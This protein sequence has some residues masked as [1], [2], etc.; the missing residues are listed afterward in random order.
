[1]SR[2][3][4]LADSADKDIAG[5][6]TLDGL[7]VSGDVAVDTDTLF[8]D[9]SAD[10]VGIGTSSPDRTLTVNSGGTN[11]VATFESTDS[12]AV[13][14]VAD[15]NSANT[16]QVGLGA[17]TDDMLLYAGGTERMR[18]D[19]SGALLVGTTSNRP[20]EFTHPAGFSV[21]GNATGQV[22]ASTD[23]AT[24][25]LLN[26]DSS[27]GAIVE[28]RKD[29]TAVGTIG[30]YGGAT[31]YTGP[32]SGVL[33][34]GVQMEPTTGTGSARTDNTNDIGS[35]TYRYRNLYLSGGVY[36][37]GTGSANKLDDYEEGTFTATL[38]GT[39]EPGTLVATAYARYTKIG[40]A[41]NYSI[42]FENQNYSG[43]SGDVEIVGLPFT[44][45]PTGRAIAPLAHYNALSHSGD[46]IFAIIE[47]SQAKIILYRS[48]SAGSWQHVTHTGASGCYIWVT[49]T[50]YT[51]S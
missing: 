12:T 16:S 44:S 13:V 26:R 3:R 7:S 32:A 47:G 1:M 19:S 20:A 40:N 34:N 49:G 38:R 23:A 14:W 25:L 17:V 30:A 35:P 39:V 9:A 37:G 8:V 5:T 10:S 45:V 48:V 51:N 18:I 24:C 46:A 43:Y 11:G 15:G 41:V 31:Y 42:S 33:F 50:Y 6:L 36:L 22:Q 29:G 28:F 27:D 21:G 2:A 4:D